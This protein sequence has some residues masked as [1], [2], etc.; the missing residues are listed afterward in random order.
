MNNQLFL[1]DSLDDFQYLISEQ[2]NYS[3][4]F[5]IRG[6]VSR[7][8]A[9]NKNKRYY[10]LEVMRESVD[11]LQPIIQRG[12]FVGEIEHPCL[13]SND[14]DILSKDG[15]KPF[16]DCKIGDEVATFNKNDVIEYQPIE[17]IIDKPFKGKVYH[18][19]GRGIDS[20]FTA[21]HRHYLEDRYG[22]RVI[23]TTK[24]IIENRK[25]FDKHKITKI[26]SWVGNEKNE[27]IIPGISKEEINNYFKNTEEIYLDE[28]FLEIDEI[29]HD[30][31]VYCITVPNGN[32]YMKQNG[33]AF[34]TGNSSPKV[35]V[36][37]I[38]HKITKMKMADD[39]A[40]IAEMTIL[41]TPQ[42]RILKKLIEG[43]VYLGVSTRALGGVRP[44]PQLG[45][46]IVEVQ[47]GLNMKA[48]DVVFDPSAGDDGRPD[49]VNESVTESGIYLGYSRKLE[50]I[51]EDIF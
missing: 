3:K 2:D 42:G 12:G 15:W 49:F 33:K 26:G 46:G 19:K 25:K 31:N 45:E 30:G 16:I 18:F 8:G 37:R 6:I 51:L 9:I 47:P 41:D 39:G 38:S 24:E 14:F 1:E 36:E 27:V 32:F 48:I 28:R 34:L 40:V 23:A 20:T 7:A 50:N 35:N 5:F 17:T 13:N 21:T 43:Q 4:G 22:K 44:N 29:D 11:N 10:P